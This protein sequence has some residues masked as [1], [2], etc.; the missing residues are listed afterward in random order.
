M[1]GKRKYTIQ[2]LT[3]A[4]LAMSVAL[5]VF[6]PGTSQGRLF[7]QCGE[8]LEDFTADPKFRSI[9]PDLSE[10]ELLTEGDNPYFPLIPGYEIVLASEDE[11]VEIVVTDD[12]EMVG[13]LETRVVEEREFEIIDDGNGAAVLR[14]LEISYNFF[15]FCPDSGAVYY[16]GEDVDV[17]NWDEEG[18]FLG[19]THP[20]EWREG[21]GALAGQIMPGLDD[22]DVKYRFYQEIAP[23]DEALD[24]GKVHKIF[25]EC[26]VNGETF[27]ECVMIIDSSDCS[28]EKD[29]KIY[30]YGV[31]IVQDEDLV[32]TPEE[33]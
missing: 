20:G 30:A 19:I 9:F 13:D 8:E 14:T 10:C 33:P 29:I 31:G 4:V 18:N 1:V 28:P 22:I 3:V 25:E 5:T 27:N 24:K 17:W 26:E 12:T 11:L 23:A 7:G 6:T 21:E 15:T 32:F 16:H 2:T